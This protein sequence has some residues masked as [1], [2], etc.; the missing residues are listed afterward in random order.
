[1]EKILSDRV[2]TR[3]VEKLDMKEKGVAGLRGIDSIIL[4]TLRSHE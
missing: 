1:M 4:V 3:I 2:E